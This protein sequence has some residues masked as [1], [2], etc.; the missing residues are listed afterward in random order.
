MTQRSSQRTKTPSERAKESDMGLYKKTEDKME[1]IEERKDI[2]KKD[3]IK[4]Q[5][6][7]QQMDESKLLSQVANEEEESKLLNIGDETKYEME[8]RENFEE[9]EFSLT[10]TQRETSTIEKCTKCQEE[11]G[12][13][14][15]LL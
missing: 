1:K 13:N 7:Q 3:L 5:E 9:E 6:P 2:K 8:D 10:S 4:E 15:Q 12:N 14:M 11:T